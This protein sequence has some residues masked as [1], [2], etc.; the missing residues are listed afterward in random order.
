MSRSQRSKARSS[1][2]YSNRRVDIATTI[3]SLPMYL[4]P[5]LSFSGPLDFRSWG[6]LKAFS[7]RE[8]APFCQKDINSHTGRVYQ[9]TGRQFPE[10]QEWNRT[11]VTPPRIAPDIMKG[12]L[13]LNPAN[14]SLP[15]IPESCR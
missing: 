6:T 15:R 4:Y 10:K 7:R 5:S 12:T 14:R 2:K 3:N 1:R 8:I 11:Q 9:K 13:S